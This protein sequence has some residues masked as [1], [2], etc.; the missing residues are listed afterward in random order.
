MPSTQ[1]IR[2]Y[3]WFSGAEK[4]STANSAINAGHLAERVAG[5]LDPQSTDAEVLESVLVATDARG[6]GY[7]AGDE[8]A[9]DETTPYAICSE[10]DLVTLHLAAGES[11]T[12][13]EG[14]DPTPLVPAGNG[15]VRA[16]NLGGTD[17][18]AMIIAVADETIDNSG[19]G[20]AV[21]CNAEVTR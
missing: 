12:G 21:L 20:S 7:E 16:A 15:E 19:G 10:G 13:G 5:G 9:A 1:V 8:Y 18:E 14:T 4:E 3:R 2:N 17:T 6:R 11:V